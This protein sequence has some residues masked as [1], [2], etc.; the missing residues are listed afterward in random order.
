M[1]GTERGDQRDRDEND[2]RKYEGPSWPTSEPSHDKSQSSAQHGA[3]EHC[4]SK[5]ARRNV[6]RTVCPRSSCSQDNARR[7][8]MAQ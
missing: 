7:T 5:A 2:R 8:P 3:N 6:L 1:C 4:Q